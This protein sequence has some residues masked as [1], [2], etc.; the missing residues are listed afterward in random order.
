MILTLRA[1]KSAIT[2]YIASLPLKIFDFEVPSYQPGRRHEQTPPQTG[3]SLILLMQPAYP[4]LGEGMPLFRTLQVVV[5][6][7]LR[8]GYKACKACET[9]PVISIDDFK[10]MR[11]SSQL[12]R[13]A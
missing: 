5:Q 13:H 11:R 2:K 9:L 10:E 8:A 4:G 6:K 3:R 12:V 1:K 7:K